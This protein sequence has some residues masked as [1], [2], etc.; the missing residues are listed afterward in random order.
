MSGDKVDIGAQ[1]YYQGMTNSNG[2]SLQASDL[3]NSLAS[4]LAGLSAPAHEAFSSLN[5]S[6]SS[7][8]LA[9]LNSSLN[10]QNGADPSKPQAYLNWVLLDNQ[11]N[12]VGGNN[13]SGAL[14]VGASGTQ[15]GGQLQAPLAYKGLPITK[16]GYLYI[17]VSNATPGWDV[18]F[19]NLSV[20]HYSGAMLEENHYYPFGLQMSGI[21]DKALKSQYAQNKHRYNGKELQNQE[22]GDGSGLEQYDY[23]ARFYDP[24]IGRWQVP[25]P[26]NEHEY[27][28]ALDKSLADEQELDDIRDD[29]EAMD[30]ARNSVNK[31]LRILGPINL[32]AENSAV[33]YNES[34]YAYVMNSPLRYIDPL[35]LDSLPTVTKIGYTHSSSSN[36]IPWWLGPGLV[37][38][39]QPVIPKSSWLVKQAFGHAFEVGRNKSTSVA[40]VASRVVVRKVE[41]KIGKKVAAKIGEKAA[42]I[43]FKRAGGFVGRAVPGVG[44]ALTAYDVYQLNGAIIHWTID[45]AADQ[46]ERDDW[47]MAW[48]IAF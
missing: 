14:Q 6:S 29:K 27:Q 42:G 34:P 38:L 13:Q 40:S 10:N 16:S 4:G 30:D 35:G 2:P 5:N 36:S 12:Y 11:F 47:A 20:T 37:A 43:L 25:D 15:S 48:G 41:Q 18:F 24:Q 3:L 44:W 39:G 9:A 17:Y 45:G 32:T 33:H 26:L 19:D 23:G 21:S 31:Y 8:L 7:P 22:F 46:E 1:Y 28:Y